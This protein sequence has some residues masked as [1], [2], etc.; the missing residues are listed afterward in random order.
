MHVERTRVLLHLVSSMEEDVAGAYR[1]VRDELE[2]YGKGIENKP[3]IVALSQTDIL[4]EDTLAEKTAQ[5]TEEVG[6]EIYKISSIAGFGMTDIL[7]ALR[8]IIDDKIAD[9]ADE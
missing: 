3:E 7:R 9:E 5:L 8:K 1:T 4:D 6:K 2:A